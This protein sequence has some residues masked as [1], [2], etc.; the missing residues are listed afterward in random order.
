MAKWEDI[1]NVIHRDYWDKFPTGT[2]LK[3]DYEGSITAIKI[4]RKSR[5]KVWGKHIELYKDDEVSVKVVDR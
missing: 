3:F 2:V 1:T 4:M 5:G